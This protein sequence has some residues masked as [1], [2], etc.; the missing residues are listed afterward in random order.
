MLSRSEVRFVVLLLL[1]FYLV[2]CLFLGLNPEP[3]EAPRLGVKSEPQLPAYAA[4]TATPD[5]SRLCNLHH[6][7]RQ[8]QIPDP[9]SEA[10]DGTRILLDARP[11][12]NP[13]NHKGNSQ[14]CH[15]ES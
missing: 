8:R 1:L 13:L 3:M 12:H 15:S 11:V 14:Q 6:S 4:A 9:L 7:S 10:R 5:L 2:V